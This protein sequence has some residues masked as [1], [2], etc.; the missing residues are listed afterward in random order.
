MT[1]GENIQF[2]RK[3]KNLSQEQ[4]GEMLFVSRQTVSQWEKD[5]TTPTVDKLLKLKEVFGVSVD[6]LL[7][8]DAKAVPEN[9]LDKEEPLES[10]TVTYQKDEI[11]R[12]LMKIYRQRIFPTILLSIP[13]LTICVV[14]LVDKQMW[15]SGISGGMVLIN[16]IAIVKGY[17]AQK[18]LIRDAE[19]K[20]ANCKFH[21]QV[22]E[23]Y[24]M[25]RISCNEEDTATQKM[26]YSEI[27]KIR[28]YDEIIIFQYRN[29]LCLIHTTDL[30]DNS[31]FYRSL[32]ARFL[33]EN[34]EKKPKRSDVLTVVSVILFV[35][36]IASLFIAIA[37]AVELS[38]HEPKMFSEYLQVALYF[39]PIPIGSV[40]FG[41]LTQ[42]K[43]YAYKKNIVVGFIMMILLIV[44]GI[45][46]R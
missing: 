35:C 23:N 37:I 42:R 33:E 25:L 7:N 16:S 24:I 44:F 10:F 20:T 1:L 13:L 3:Q 26:L 38:I 41:I 5:Q 36:S 28:Q 40:V 27:T 43:G 12:T 14:M 39:L 34:T 8:E 4:L 46:I 9:E 30:N 31:I 11:R 19:Q 45:F 32:R 15:L 21:Y 2:C 29:A 22:Y 6:E 17:L 18:K